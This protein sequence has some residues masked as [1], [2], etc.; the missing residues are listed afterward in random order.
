MYGRGT[1]SHLLD[2]AV[3]MGDKAGEQAA[4]ILREGGYVR[5][6]NADAVKIA[7]PSYH[8]DASLLLLCLVSVTLSSAKGT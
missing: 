4:D 5:C 1:D 2:F 3:R 6:L 7:E 8:A